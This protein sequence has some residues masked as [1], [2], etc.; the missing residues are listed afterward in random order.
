MFVDYRGSILG[1]LSWQWKSVLLFTV[2]ASLIVAVEHFFAEHTQHMLL[3]VAPVVVVGGAIGIFVSFRTNS[4]Y[5]RCWEGRKL[6]GALV[7][8]SRHFASQVLIYL[9]GPEDGA[10]QEPPAPSELQRA[11]VRRHIA[12]VHALRVLLRG[13]PLGEDADFCSFVSN[14]ELARVVLESSPT[15]A[16]LHTQMRALVAENEAGRLSADRLRSFDETLRALLDVQGGCERIKK[17]P[18]PRGY[19]FIADR[20]IMLYGV[21]LPL[22]IV[23]TV[24]NDWIAIPL[25]LLVCLSFLL[26][27]EVGRVLEDPF[28]HFWPALPLSALAKTIEINL[29]QRLG[30]ANLPAQPKPNERGI[31]M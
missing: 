7:N 27:S 17:T 28:T 25:T 21:L 24:D 6:W 26:I 3:P 18:F 11:L 5:D 30:E 19:G 9:P 12:Y 31:L 15:H 10:A 29:R 4:A 8:S 22:G 2:A 20:L 14:K 13:D 16:L 1:L 23:G